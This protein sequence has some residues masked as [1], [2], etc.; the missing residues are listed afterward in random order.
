MGSDPERSARAERA[1]L[2]IPKN[3]ARAQWGRIGGRR[4]GA[5]DEGRTLSTR[6]SLKFCAWTSVLI[7]AV[8]R[9]GGGSMWRRQRGEKR[10]DLARACPAR[11]R[12]D[13]TGGRAGS[14][15]RVGHAPLRLELIRRAHRRV[16]HGEVELHPSVRRPRGR[17]W[18]GEAS[19]G[20]FKN[21]TASVR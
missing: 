2:G 14:P 10:S 9:E 18:A 16:E 4:G 21:I 11:A 12:A 1:G 8:L 19:G 7:S 3:D 13:G 20:R 6:G 5:G 17:E 15:A